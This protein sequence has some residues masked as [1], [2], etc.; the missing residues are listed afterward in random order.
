L[1]FVAL[2]EMLDLDELP[3][4]TA[5]MRRRITLSASDVG[6]TVFDTNSP[7]PTDPSR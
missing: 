4:M 2:L 6:R 3:P 7:L 5:D 1:S